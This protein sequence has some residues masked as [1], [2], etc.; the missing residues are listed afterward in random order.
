[1]KDFGNMDKIEKKKR[2]ENTWKEKKK[3]RKR[4]KSE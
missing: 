4:E 2:K 1:M 3:W